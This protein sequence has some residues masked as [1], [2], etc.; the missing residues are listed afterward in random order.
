MTDGTATGYAARWLPLADGS[1]L[2]AVQLDSPAGLSAQFVPSVGMVG[3]SLS[4]HG[5]VL[6]V[7]VIEGDF[8]F[9]IR[10][11]VHSP[12]RWARSWAS[13]AWPCCL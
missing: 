11:G 5:Q 13:S 10:M 2:A 9:G 6:N 7:F 1:G 12:L 8:E 4:H 3:C